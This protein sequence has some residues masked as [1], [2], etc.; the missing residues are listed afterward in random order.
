MFGKKNKNYK[1]AAGI[2]A[3]NPIH[4]AFNYI[5]LI[6]LSAMVI[7]PMLIVFIVSFKTNNEYISTD[8]LKLPNS[9]LNFENYRVIIQEA[10]LLSGLKNTLIMVIVPTFI[11]VIM[12]TMVAYVVTR[13]DFWGKKL[14]LGLFVLSSL[15]PY[16]IMQIG[17]FAVIKNLGIFNTRYAGLLIYAAAGVVEIYIFIQHIEKIPVALDES[18]LIEGASFFRIYRSIILPLSKP[19]IATVVI[20]R[21]LFIYNDMVMPYLLMPKQSL[22]TIVTCFLNYSYDNVSQ[23]NIMGAGI[24]TILL[25]AVT[26]YIFIQRYIFAGITDG[27]V[28]D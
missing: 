21:A 22:R 24:I 11:T 10:K 5:L 20:L 3:T 8:I 1:F 15:I 17:Q 23:W 12:G 27:A 7:M 16:I 28:K 9:F 18:A 4:I 6:L 19:A 2:H 25:P 13:F 26:I 14:V